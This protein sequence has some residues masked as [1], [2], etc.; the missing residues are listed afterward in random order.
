MP[1]MHVK[2]RPTPSLQASLGP[3]PSFPQSNNPPKS[4]MSSFVKPGT[5]T[6]QAE[7]TRPRV[8]VPLMSIGFSGSGSAA[9]DGMTSSSTSPRG[10]LGDDL[11]LIGNNNNNNPLAQCSLGYGLISHCCN[12]QP[13]TNL[14]ALQVPLFGVSDPREV[15]VV[16]RRHGCSSFLHT[17]WVDLGK[18]IMWKSLLTWITH[19]LMCPWQ[20]LKPNLQSTAPEIY[21]N[22]A[23]D[24]HNLFLPV[25]PEAGPITLHGLFTIVSLLFSIVHSV[26]MK[27]SPGGR[28]PPVWVFQNQRWPPRWPPWTYKSV[29]LRN[30]CSKYSTIALLVLI[31]MFLTLRNLIIALICYLVVILKRNA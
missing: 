12:P 1:L 4:L 11:V 10:Q 22:L 7:G 25:S 27:F 16:A 24:L 19:R 13:D 6:M 21:Q 8:P 9:D 31:I 15:S 3:R 2:P 29:I 20:D 17:Y 30:V 18:G 14:L 28:L 5:Q 26:S 23:G